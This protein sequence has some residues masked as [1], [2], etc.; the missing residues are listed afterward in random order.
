MQ[1]ICTC[2]GVS[3]SVAC[4]GGTAG[5]APSGAAL[6][7]VSLGTL[8]RLSPA[9]RSSSWARSWFC[10]ITSAP[11]CSQ[12]TWEQMKAWVTFP[13]TYLP[14]KFSGYRAGKLTVLDKGEVLKSLYAWSSKENKKR[15][16]SSPKDT[17]AC[18]S[19]LGVSCDISVL[20]AEFM[21]R[22]LEARLK[23]C[24]W[25]LFYLFKIIIYLFLII[26]PAHPAAFFIYDLT[27][28]LP[29]TTSV[30]STRGKNVI[31][32]CMTH[33][34]CEV[35]SNGSSFGHF[36]WIEAQQKLEFCKM[37]WTLSFHIEYTEYILCFLKMPFFFFFLSFPLLK[38]C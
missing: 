22:E 18:H 14:E 9:S 1:P 31:G 12:K 13:Q 19:F 26:L 23:L 32:L 38:V 20:P 2:S 5:S 6:V 11:S 29:F 7:D 15:S 28:L 4:A 8:H 36:N 24:V 16:C 3:S 35:L 25:L 17:A 34:S 37:T 33:G 30:I 10:G 21:P 27:A